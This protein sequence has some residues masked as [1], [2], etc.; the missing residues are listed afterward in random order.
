MFGYFAGAIVIGQISFGSA[1]VKVVCACLK[2]SPHDFGQ[3][4]KREPMVA[5]SARS[6]TGRMERNCCQLKG[7]VIGRCKTAIRR[8]LNK[9]RVSH[10]TFNQAHE[11]GNLFCGSPVGANAPIS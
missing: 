9:S 10:I 6:V 7:G 3:H 4:V 5:G 11:I 1:V 2:F 8:E